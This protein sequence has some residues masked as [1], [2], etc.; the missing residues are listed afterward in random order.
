MNRYWKITL[1]EDRDDLATTAG[2]DDLG[3]FPTFFWTIGKRLEHPAWPLDWKIYVDDHERPLGD[4]VSTGL[5]VPVWSRH[6]VEVISSLAPQDLQTFPAPLFMR[7]EMRRVPGYYMVNVTRALPCFSYEHSQF[8]YDPHL[9]GRVQRIFE[10]VLKRGCVPPDVHAF[11]LSDCPWA[12]IFCSDAARQGL[13]RLDGFGF[14]DVK[15]T[16]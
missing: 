13:A 16:S 11:R 10:L 12:G 6:A 9:H 8:A 14:L 4:H 2:Y 3:G 15:M 7:P 1:G 5:H